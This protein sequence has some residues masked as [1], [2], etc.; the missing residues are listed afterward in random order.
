MFF[1]FK[2]DYV[3]DGAWDDEHTYPLT[4]ETAIPL[5]RDMLKS[6]YLTSHR[7]DSAFR[8]MKTGAFSSAENDSERFACR[9]ANALALNT[10]LSTININCKLVPVF[11]AVDN[12]SSYEYVTWS[13]AKIK[14]PGAS[15][16]QLIK[17]LNGIY[18]NNS[19]NVNENTS[20]NGD[21]NTPSKKS[22]CCTII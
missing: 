7:G 4:K 10:F 20:L 19:L 12:P 9:K 5:I 14:F 8:Y 1:A 15:V 17:Q 3:R 16:N 22:S 21:A 13:E 18:P 6:E 2:R 11:S